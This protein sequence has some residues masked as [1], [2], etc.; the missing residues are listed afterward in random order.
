MGVLYVGVK[1]EEFFRSF[2][3]L[4]VVAAGVAA[5]M[6]LIFGLVGRRRPAC[7]SAASWGLP[8]PP[9]RSAWAKS[10]KTPLDSKS[11]DEIGE[12][13]KSIDRLRESMR[14]AL[15]RLNA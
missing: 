9:M 12:L 11:Q 6:A 2:R 10:S 5:V 13:T 15:K 7:C 14:E 3:H 1:Q 8:R 4:V